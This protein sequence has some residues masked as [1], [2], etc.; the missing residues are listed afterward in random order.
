MARK[1]LLFTDEQLKDAWDALDGIPIVERGGGLCVA[2]ISEDP[3]GTAEKVIRQMRD[4]ARYLKKNG[5][6]RAKASYPEQMP[7]GVFVDNDT[8]I[9]EYSNKPRPAYE[10]ALTRISSGELASA[11]SVWAW[12]VDRMCRRVDDGYNFYRT[13]RENLPLGFVTDVEGRFDFEE[14]SGDFKRFMDYCTA[15][16]AESQKIAKRRK[17]TLRDNRERRKVFRGG[18]LIPGWKKD[19]ESGEL[20][21]HPDEWKIIAKAKD[22][23]LTGHGWMAITRDWNRIEF[24]GREDWRCGWVKRGPSCYFR[25]NPPNHSRR[26]TA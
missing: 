18:R 12:A 15:A 8:S 1:S 11:G 14:G 24:H 9:S 2:R 22:D 7:A 4:W 3:N 13:M 20:V 16:Q 5:L 23:R 25:T 10:A 17:N 19:K 21:P 6:S 26:T